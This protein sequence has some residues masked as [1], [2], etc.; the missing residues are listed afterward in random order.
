M[1]LRR[2]IFTTLVIVCGFIFTLPISSSQGL[3]QE[4]EKIRN[5]W[6]ASVS[7]G[8]YS[9][10][11]LWAATGFVN[12]M[13]IPSWKLWV[14]KPQAGF[15]VSGLGSYMA[16]AGL[17]WPAKPLKWLV[18][19]T[20]AAAGYYESG[21]GIDLHYPL[22][23]KL[24]IAVMFRFRNSMELGMEFDHISNADLGPPNPG[25]ESISVV[26][27]IPLQKTKAY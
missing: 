25:T 21:D 10:L 15:L 24:S 4:P 23:F 3:A 17:V 9:C 11:D 26:F 2:N 22:E 8:E 13:V 20:G 5:P 12:V 1:K 27:Q 18:I 19:Q 6:Y 14:L 7:A 16:Y